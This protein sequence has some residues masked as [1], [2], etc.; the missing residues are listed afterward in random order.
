M[1]AKAHFIYHYRTAQSHPSSLKYTLQG[2][3]PIKLAT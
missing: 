3:A 2:D 1:V